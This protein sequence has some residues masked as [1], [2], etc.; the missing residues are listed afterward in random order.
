MG[1]KLFVKDG[2]FWPAENGVY[3]GDTVN[4]VLVAGGNK[5][6]SST[7]G[8]E[9]GGDSS[10]GVYAVAIGGSGA[11]GTTTVNVSPYKGAGGGGGFI[12]GSPWQGGA[13]RNGSVTG[14]ISASNAGGGG[15]L[16]GANGSNFGGANSSGSGEAL[17]EGGG[18]Y[19]AGGGAS[20]TSTQV[21]SG[22]AGQ[23]LYYSHI[24]TEDDM[25][26][27]IPITIGAGANGSDSYYM[28]Y[29][30]SG[31]TITG[32]KATAG[33]IKSP[34]YWHKDYGVH[35]TFET[36]DGTYGMT[37]AG[38]NYAY[39]TYTSHVKFMERDDVLPFN[40]AFP[41]FSNSYNWSLFY[42][43]G[44]Y[45]NIQCTTSQTT[46]QYLLAETARSGQ[47]TSNDMGT[48]VLPASC[49]AGANATD[50][51]VAT[52]SATIDLYENWTPTATPYSVTLSSGL[53]TGVINYSVLIPYGND[54]FYQCQ[55]EYSNTSQSSRRVITNYKTGATSMITHNYYLVYPQSIYG[56]VM[57]SR[58]YSSGKWYYQSCGITSTPGDSNSLYF[59]F[60]D[61]T[62]RGGEARQNSAYGYGLL[63]TKGDGVLFI[64]ANTYYDFDK[65]AVAWG[66]DNNPGFPGNCGGAGGCCMISW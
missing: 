64:K 22:N 65:Y 29:Y 25:I 55:L 2:I 38:S 32:I 18:G 6:H 42:C 10:F 46:I 62:I 37:A 4:V 16:Q 20:G 49:G 66:Y 60:G 28:A 7:P 54:R 30:P 3:P 15:L 45:L 11:P 48:I 44:Y 36:V 33:A 5:G 26:Y 9:K 35:K 23:I 19:G 61:S 27:G 57:V 8:G 58:Y 14:V 56:W 53:S 21:Y 12:P 63:P 47:A 31:T 24:I 59:W 17:G 52:A 13:G 41:G 1:M 51:V 43:N 40:T 39:P 50:L 34:Q